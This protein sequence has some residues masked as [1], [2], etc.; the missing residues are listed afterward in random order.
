MP[1]EI[2]V[3][4]IRVTALTDGTVRL[5]PMFYPGLD[6]GAHPEL[7]EPDR[8][9]HIPVGCFL[10]RGAGAPI[11]VDAGIGPDSIA[12][13]A[14]IAAAAGLDRPPEWIAEGGRLPSA[15]A[16]VGVR[17]ADI[18]LVFLT[19][20]HPDHIGWVAPGGDLFFGTAEVVHGAAEAEPPAEPAAGE[21]AARAGLEVAKAAGRLRLVDDPVVQLGPGVVA[22]HTPGHTPGHYIVSVSAGGEQAVLLGDA[23]HH[24]LQLTDPGIS[25]RTEQTPDHAL[26]TREGLFTELAGTEVAIGMTHFPGLEFQRIA[27][28]DGRRR[29]VLA[30]AG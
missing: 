20:L 29:W 16:A 12:F 30:P 22:R 4:G 7:L 18:G 15:L 27:V 1:S 3:G 26:R 2:S 17:P 8:T 14:D 6:F 28:A 13:P 10:I 24:P 9:Y 5:P 19:H 21:E 11:L 25:F 23:V